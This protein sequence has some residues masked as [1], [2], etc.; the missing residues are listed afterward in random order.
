MF[1]PHFDAF[2]DLL[3]NRRMATWNLFVLYNN[4]K[5]FL[6]W[7]YFNI[8]WKPA[9]APPLPNL[10]KTEKAIWRNLLSIQKEAILLVTVRSKELWLVQENHATVKPDSSVAP[11]GMKT[12]SESRIEPQIL[13]NLELAKSSQLRKTCGWGQPRC[14]LIWVLNERSINNGGDFCLL[15]LVI[16]K[17]VWY[18]V[19]DILAAILSTVSC[20]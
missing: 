17:L 14:H 10:V 4:E 13:K 3:L 5:P 15:R 19:R 2:C 20:G 1:L 16:L 6:F 18:S 7:K 11:H 8:M 9:F 12:Y